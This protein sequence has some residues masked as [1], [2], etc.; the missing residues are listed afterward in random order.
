MI[1]SLKLLPSDSKN[2][3]QSPVLSK[4]PYTRR[5]PRKRLFQADEYA[6]FIANGTINVFNNIPE[7]NA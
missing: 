5:T 7:K 4:L 1:N 6:N 2:S 3:I